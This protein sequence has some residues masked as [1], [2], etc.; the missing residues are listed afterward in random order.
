MHFPV[1]GDRQAWKEGPCGVGAH[2]ARPALGPS[3]R[4]SHVSPVA[5]DAGP[6]VVDVLATSRCAMGGADEACRRTRRTA[7]RLM[8][9][10]VQREIVRTRTAP[11]KAAT[12]NLRLHLHVL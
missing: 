10:P 11:L 1:K 6:S 5:H 8:R 7:W 12:V 4:L 2:A 3:E 9:E